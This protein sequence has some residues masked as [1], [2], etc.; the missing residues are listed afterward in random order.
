[1]WGRRPVL[2]MTR[3]EAIE[4]LHEI[5]VVLATTTIRDIPTEVELGPEDGMPRSCVLNADQTETLAKGFL[6]ERITRLRPEKL[7]EVC[8]ALDRAT[9]C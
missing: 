2:V 9:G 5:F 6:I 4:S 3:D 7:T 8:A 1:V